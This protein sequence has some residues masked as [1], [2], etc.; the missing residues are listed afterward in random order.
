MMPYVTSLLAPA[1]MVARWHGLKTA[2]GESQGRVDSDRGQDD[3]E[4]A[5]MRTIVYR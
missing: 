4:S 2:S 5:L 3:L 1:L